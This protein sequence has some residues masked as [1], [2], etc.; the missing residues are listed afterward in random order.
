M[1]IDTE[2]IGMFDGK[3]FRNCVKLTGGDEGRDTS[4]LSRDSLATLFVLSPR[5]LLSSISI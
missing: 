5:A 3:T 2:G 4:G 1:K